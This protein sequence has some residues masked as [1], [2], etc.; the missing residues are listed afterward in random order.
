[1]LLFV[2]CVIGVRFF[3]VQDRTEVVQLNPVFAYT[4]N[5]LHC[6]HTNNHKNQ[7]TSTCITKN[8]KKIIYIYIYIYIYISRIIS[9]YAIVNINTKL[10]LDND[11]KNL[12]GVFC[13]V[14]IELCRKYKNSAYSAQVYACQIIQCTRCTKI[15]PQGKRDPKYQNYNT[16]LIFKWSKMV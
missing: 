14:Y 4:H 13:D 1:M 6:N 7:F 9:N 16:S 15:D 3:L 8:K 10:L 2:L 5:N 11:T 12:I